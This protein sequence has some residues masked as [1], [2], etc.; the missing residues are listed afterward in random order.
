MNVK[1]YSVKVFCNNIN[2]HGVSGDFSMPMPDIEYQ[3][4]GMDLLITVEVEAIDKERALNQA[5]E[6]VQL[7]LSVLAVNWAAF[8][9]LLLDRRTQ[10]DMIKLSDED[11][12]SVD[13]EVRM[14]LTA[15]AVIHS[16]IELDLN[17]FEHFQLWP[18]H[19]KA[20]LD[21][22]LDAQCSLNEE[23]SFL[24]A[25]AALELVSQFDPK[26]ILGKPEFENEIENIV[27]E[28]ERLL[29]S[30]GVKKDDAARLIKKMKVTHDVSRTDFIFTYLL[31]SVVKSG[32]QEVPPTKQELTDW[33]EGRNKYIHRKGST[34]LDSAQL[35]RLVRLV[36]CC[37]GAELDSFSK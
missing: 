12:I 8:K 9:I 7:F 10:V 5:I 30:H 24:L 32:M 4:I 19:L 37:L 17:R 26:T 29:L 11:H 34:G 15:D 13:I 3:I 20:S 22:Y 28:I 36:G 2:G 23:V 33:I 27:S 21:L 14:T 1:K 31:E 6:K 18:K 16:S 25:M 35:I